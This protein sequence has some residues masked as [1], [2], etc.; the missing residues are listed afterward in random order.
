MWRPR[1]RRLLAR[2][3][4]SP[5]VPA[6]AADAE[7]LFLVHKDIHYGR[8]FTKNLY[9]DEQAESPLHP[10]RLFH[11]FVEPPDRLSER[12]CRMQGI[13]HARL[14]RLRRAPRPPVEQQ[15]AE[16]ETARML[17][18]GWRDW[19]AGQPASLLLT[20]LKLQQQVQL[21]AGVLAMFPAARLALVD[22]DLVLAPAVNAALAA[23]GI[24]TLAAQERGHIVFLRQPQL[25]AFDHYAVWGRAQ[26]LFAREQGGCSIGAYHHLGI[27][28][29]DAILATAARPCPKYELIRRQRRLVVALDWHSSSTPYDMGSAGY[30]SI[31][32]NNRAFYTALLRLA[33]AFPGCHFVVKGKNTDFVRQD[34]YRELLASLTA[35]PNFS[36]E[37]QLRAYRPAT[38]MAQADLV[39]ACHTSLAEEAL[40]CGKPA[41]LY[42]PFA[43]P[44]A[45][46]DAFAAAGIVAHSD[47]E[48]QDLLT[49]WQAGD[50]PAPAALAALRQEFYG[51]EAGGAVAAEL[52]RLAR[53]LLADPIRHDGG[54]T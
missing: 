27:P 10:R 49:R 52:R 46:Q 44:P 36:I 37:S 31:S 9:Y 24:I 13:P 54:R 42:N 30:P 39:I 7:A 28:R 1:L 5:A 53:Q 23:R 33:R 45:E 16:R 29:S 47:A 11:L 26:E 14:D 32:R 25:F 38:M 35:L 34:Y 20:L 12:Y 18:L 3:E 2:Q 43:Y 17:C 41:V 15:Q 22:Y 51:G 8:L 50:W 48:L 19:R 6:A 21:T 40:A 4:T